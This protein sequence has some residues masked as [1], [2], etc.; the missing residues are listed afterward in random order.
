MQ[1]FRLSSISTKTLC[2]VK[3]IIAYNTMSTL[4][5][6]HSSHQKIPIQSTETL[7]HAFIIRIEYL[8]GILIVMVQQTYT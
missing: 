5:L 3:R 6:Q 8:N 2:L 4:P 1:L 7:I